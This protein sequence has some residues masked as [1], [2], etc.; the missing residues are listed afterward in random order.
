MPSPP[1]SAPELWTCRLLCLAGGTLLVAFALAHGAA[2]L[3]AADPAWARWLVGGLALGLGVASLPSEAVRR[4]MP[5]LCRVLLAVLTVWYAAAAWLNG[6]PPTF[7][8]GGVGLVAVAASVA[9]LGRSGGVLPVG[10]VAGLL[11]VLA[12]VAWGVEDPAVHPGAFLG[13]AAA[14]GTTLLG[15][16]ALRHHLAARADEGERRFRALFEHTTDGVLLLEA[17]TLRILEANPA[18]VAMTGFERRDLRTRTLHDLSDAR[19]EAVDRD[20]AR[21]LEA[22]HAV[23]GARTHVRR[24]GTE[25]PLE[26]TLVRLDGPGDPMLCLIASDQTEQERARAEAA[27]A[28]THAETMQALQTTFLNNMSHE[29]RTP[30]VALTGFLEL[31]EEDELDSTERREVV[32]SL[33]RSALRLHRTLDA[34]LDLA[35]L[36][37]GRPDL[38][39]EPVPVATVV[40]EALPPFREEARRKGLVLDLRVGEPARALIDRAALHRI[41][42][43]LVS[44]AVKFTAAGRVDVEV[45]ADSHRVFVRVRDTGP[46]IPPDFLPHLFAPFRQGSSGLGREHEGTGLGLTITKRLVDLMGG[47]IMVESAPGEGTT[48]TVAFARTWA[49]PTPDGDG[50]TAVAEAPPPGLPPTIT[51]L[52]ARPRALVV[53][54]NADTARLMERLLANAFTVERAADGREALEMACRTWYDLVLLD[55]NLGPGLDGISVL[56]RLRALSAYAYVPVVAVT[57]YTA[58]GD[59]ER[60]LAAGFNAYLPKPFDRKALRTAVEH[61]YGACAR[62]GTAPLESAPAD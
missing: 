15:T 11:A 43:A 59:R 61:A 16:T 3:P 2:D 37:S 57:T 44:N 26:A 4:E 58:P 29:L 17:S 34:L 10:I 55:I 9:G 20:A 13:T 35:R 27:A 56:R 48:V 30:L 18:Y 25:L 53:E 12:G 54:D 33:R 28:R 19:P 23:L 8:A 40:H 1:P 45:G 32:G 36:E 21:T 47:R 38:R 24:D 6:L 49:T 60:F 5:G 42:T 39:P 14:V 22:G 31:L 7:A 62:L 52:A 51:P 50:A 41:V 46:G